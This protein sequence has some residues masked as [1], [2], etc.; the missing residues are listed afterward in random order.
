LP[1]TLLLGMTALV[2][3]IVCT[4]VASLLLAR[5]ASRTG[6]M[7]IR[8][9]LGAGRGRLAR[10]LFLESA[11]VPIIGGLCSLPIAAAT[12]AIQNEA[13]SARAG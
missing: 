13:D 11:T 10:Q 12:C 8:A 7:A 1:L 6:E 9:S 4:N 2:L 3:L 5:G